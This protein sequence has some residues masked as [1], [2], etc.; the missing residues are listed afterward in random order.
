MNTLK[1][2]R[3]MA[4]YTQEDMAKTINI[5]RMTYIK[6]EKD[7]TNFSFN[8]KQIIFSKLKEKLPTLTMEELFPIN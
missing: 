1:G 6:K 8:E 4:G 2:Y 5:G 7:I 3:V